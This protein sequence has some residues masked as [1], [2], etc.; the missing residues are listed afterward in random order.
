MQKRAGWVLLAVIS[1]GLGAFAETVITS[2]TGLPDESDVVLEKAVDAVKTMPAETVE[3][4]GGAVLYIGD[5]LRNTVHGIA[6]PFKSD[7]REKSRRELLL[8]TQEAWST[9]RQLQMKAYTVSATVGSE[10]SGDAT[11]G[12]IDVSPFFAGVDFPKG[13]SAWYRPDTRRLVVCN[14]PAGLRAVEDMLLR[15]HKAEREYKQVEIQAKF[16]EVSQQTLNQLGFNWDVTDAVKI[17]GGWNLDANDYGAGLRTA[18]AALRGAPVAGTM[19]LTKTGWMPLTLVISALEQDSDSD[20]LSSPSLTTMDGKTA[21]IWVGERRNV[22]QSFKVNSSSVN[23]HIE[24]TK[25]DSQLM[26]VQFRVTPTIEKANNIRLKLNP[27]VLD[28]IGYDTY[29][30]SPEASMLMVNGFSVEQTGVDGAYPL[31]NVPAAGITKV[32]DLMSATLGGDVNSQANV[33]GNNPAIYSDKERPADHET[34]GVPLAP[35]Q[36][37]LPYFRVREIETEVVVADGNTVGLGGLIYDRLETY[38]D[39]VP[40]L[41]SIP[42]IGRLFRSEGERSIKR[43][44]MIFVSAT[45][46]DGNGQRKTDLASTN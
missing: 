23:V 15:C 31:L 4:I 22:P 14:T 7:P 45:Q 46:V 35:V 24:H 30:V 2:S 18:A 11:G 29:Q 19:T 9:D 36:G 42:L 20:V 17:A 34:Y 38:K 3:A 25:W 44:L 26:G 12:P 16:I 27:K 28:L 37:R 6:S 41:G 10:L 8:N 21:D 13:S 32:W 5:E 33:I 39:K 40:V 1:I 43:N